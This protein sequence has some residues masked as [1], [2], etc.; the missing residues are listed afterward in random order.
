MFDMGKRGVGVCLLFTSASALA[1]GVLTCPQ[2][3]FSPDLFEMY[4]K[5]NGG[6]QD[7]LNKSLSEIMLLADRGDP[8]ASAAVAKRILEGEDKTL[9]PDHALS[10]LESAKAAEDPLALYLS[11][12]L[13]RKGH[14]LRRNLSQAH[15]D[16]QKAADFGYVPAKA[17]VAA[18]YMIGSG[19]KT[20]F[21]KA[22]SYAQS[23]LDEGYQGAAQLLGVM[24]SKGLGVP[25]DETKGFQLSKR[26]AS[27]GH[28]AAQF[29][30]ARALLFGEGVAPDRDAAYLYAQHSYCSGVKLAGMMLGKIELEKHSPESTALAI[31]Y[32]SELSDDENSDANLVLADIYLDPAYGQYDLDRALYYLSKAAKSG[33]EDAKYRWGAALLRF[34]RNSGDHA[35][36]EKILLECATSGDVRAQYDLG[37][38]YSRGSEFKEDKENAK[39]WFER[40][41]AKGSVEAEAALGELQHKN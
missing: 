7:V 5:W 29:D 2:R 19:V 37:V 25:K 28:P 38:A 30:V 18:D 20:D 36:S 27:I 11:G 14:R 33:S 39:R 17:S 40:A 10:Y 21:T 15:K 26:A 6:Y 35:L 8:R 4:E 3:N 13:E 31:K 32:Y 1:G 9:S 23:A 12:M 41:A 24:Y 22:H 16:F 34:G